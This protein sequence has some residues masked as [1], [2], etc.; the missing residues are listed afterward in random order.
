MVLCKK[1]LWKIAFLIIGGVI[2]CVGCLLVSLACCASSLNFC[3]QYYFVYFKEQDD[4]VSAASI[5]SAVESLGG[6]GYIL[7]CDGKFYV[8]VA[9][10]YSEKDANTVC[11]NL[12]ARNLKC[13][14][15][16]K[17][18]DGIKLVSAYAKNNKDLYKGN[19]NT[20]HSLSRLCY[21]IANNLDSGTYT[22]VQAK[23][24]LDGVIS[25]LN[26]LLLSNSGNAFTPYLS[27]LVAVADD[28]YYDFVYSRD[29]RKLQIAIIDTIIN[30]NFN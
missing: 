30:V 17:Q 18:V 11:G 6:A 1:G 5:S 4:A 29:V 10:Y 8:T 2:L 16:E 25:S 21:D 9:C 27:S 24:A 22:Q 20:L 26:G 7:E 19:L 14:V 3:A 28:V 15:L 13:G 23:G 12:Q